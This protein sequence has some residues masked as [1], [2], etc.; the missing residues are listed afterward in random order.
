MAVSSGVDV[1]VAAVKGRAAGGAGVRGNSSVDADVT[2]D[3][4]K[5]AGR[6]AAGAGMSDS[7]GVDVND[8]TV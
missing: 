4:G 8:T 3:G 1:N 5:Y 6:A 2:A 7:S